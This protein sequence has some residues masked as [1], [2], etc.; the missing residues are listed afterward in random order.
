MDEQAVMEEAMGNSADVEFWFTMGS[1]YT[2][3]SVMR[4]PQIE[5]S[6]GI[7]F[8][9]HPF[10]RRAVGGNVP[11][12]EGSPKTAY[13]WRDIERRAAMYNLPVRLP[14]PYPAKNSGTA[15]LV[16]FVGM[17][18]GWGAAFVQA[19]YRRWFQ[20]G[21]ETGSEPNFSDSLREVGQDPQRVIDLAQSAQITAA[22]QARSD[23]ARER[24]LFGA[25]SF[26]VGNE[27]FWGDDRLEDALSWVQ[28]GK[29]IRRG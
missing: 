22:W 27:V 7:R 19:A 6:T 5:K 21:Q 2:Y 15:N 13:M 9:W 25:P 1:T 20:L 14:V 10:D 4:V 28:H 18:D 12:P 24:G 16:G 11:Y 29:V 23:R 3:F 26:V 17:Q 8:S